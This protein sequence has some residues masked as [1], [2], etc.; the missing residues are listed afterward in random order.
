M[1][2]AD[3][4]IKLIATVLF[5]FVLVFVAAV[6]TQLMDPVYTNVV[7]SQEMT[8]LG[9]GAPQ[10]VVYLFMTISMIA[11]GIVVILWWVASPIRDDV[12]QEETRPPF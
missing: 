6:G 9:W 8:D 5:V 10:D 11:L 4:I 2:G 3:T 12:R 7:D 1:A